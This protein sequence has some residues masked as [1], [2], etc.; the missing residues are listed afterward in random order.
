M[1]KL[2]NVMSFWSLTTAVAVILCSTCVV[3]AALDYNPPTWRGAPGST[4][5]QW[6]FE[7]SGATVPI[8]PAN[9]SS[10]DSYTNPNGVASL[11]VNGGFPQAYWKPTDLG[12]T[13]VWRFEDDMVITIPNFIQENPYKEVRLQMTFYAENGYVPDVFLTPV[14]GTGAFMNLIDIVADGADYW[15]ATFQGFMYPNPTRE[16]IS[17][18]PRDCSIYIDD[19][20]VDTNCVPEPMT[21]S[22]LGAGGLALLRK[23]K[24]R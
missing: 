3:N 21:L 17:I 18:I 14:N 9:P 12:H 4:V 23:R 15:S 8:P 7:G 13:G 6:E 11:L 22:L 24:R 1:N 10:P 19:I 5:Q 2:K 16:T 20:V